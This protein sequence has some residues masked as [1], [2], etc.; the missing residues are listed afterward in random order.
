MC[1]IVPA[2]HKDEEKKGAHM[3]KKYL[4]LGLGLLMAAG[5]MTG[6]SSAKKETEKA[7]VKVLEGL[8]PIQVK[9]MTTKKY[10][11]SMGKGE[12]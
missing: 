1:C 2:S 11:T 8:S 9:I 12:K 6:C 3:K 5:M 4:A 10:L 7:T